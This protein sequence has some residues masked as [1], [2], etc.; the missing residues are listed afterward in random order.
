MRKSNPWTKP[1]SLKIIVKI[2]S[3]WGVV[4]GS[5]VIQSKVK[6]FFNKTYGRR[7]GGRW[8][9]G[10]ERVVRKGGD[11]RVVKKGEMMKGWWKGGRGY[12]S[13]KERWGVM[14]YEYF[15]K[16]MY[17]KEGRRDKQMNQTCL[18]DELLDARGGWYVICVM[19]GKV[20]NQKKEEE[21]EK[22]V[23]FNEVQG[24]Y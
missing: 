13:G 11:V 4:E 17:V 16:Y 19:W 7:V 10:D 2:W 3:W 1:W 6:E 21:K 23:L 5:V 12:I 24:I 8:K 15:L 14:Q 20:N 22:R 9:D 18:R